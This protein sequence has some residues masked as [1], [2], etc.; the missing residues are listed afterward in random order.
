MGAK[1][2]QAMTR[3]RRECTKIVMEGS[4][5]RSAVLEEKAK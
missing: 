3:D 5:Q 1:N 2:K 4:P